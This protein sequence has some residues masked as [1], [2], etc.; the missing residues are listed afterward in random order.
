MAAQQRW[1]TSGQRP[2]R[3]AAVATALYSP[4]RRIRSRPARS[5]ANM[6]CS[7]EVNGPL[8]M[9]S[10]DNVPVSPTATS[11]TTL[12]D[13]AYAPPAPANATYSAA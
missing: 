4:K 7:K 1:P 12:P 5:V 6:A 3:P 13:N 10:V 11:T 9:M 2:Q 8:S